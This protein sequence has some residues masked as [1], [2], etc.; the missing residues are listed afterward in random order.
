[1]KFEFLIGSDCIEMSR[2]EVKCSSNVNY[3]NSNKYSNYSKNSNES[4]SNNTVDFTETES[5][6]INIVIAVT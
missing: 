6:I 5:I 3:S 2:A 4:C 1:M